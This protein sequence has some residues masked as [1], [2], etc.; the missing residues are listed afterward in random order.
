M[1]WRILWRINPL[2]LAVMVGCSGIPRV[3]RTD[4][5]KEMI[6][7]HIPRTADLQ[8]MEL[9]EA[10]FQEA[11]RQ[12]AREVRVTGTP[13]QMAE[14]MFQMDPQSGNYLYLPRD[15][16]LVPAGPG[17]SLE[18]TLTKEDLET[19]ERYRLW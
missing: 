12:L 4:T 19:A 9:E 10:E 8:P 11:M 18:G 13:R 17:A 16:K 2:V 3:V 6:V 14:R 15:R 5:G 7:V 1:L